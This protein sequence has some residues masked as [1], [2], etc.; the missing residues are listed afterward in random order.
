MLGPKPPGALPGEAPLGSLAEV[1]GAGVSL[2]ID[3]G[4]FPSLAS[5]GGAQPRAKS[6]FW[7]L[8]ACLVFLTGGCAETMMG[9]GVE[10]DVAQLRQ[11]V[12]A[13][14]L[15]VHRSRSNTETL[16]SQLDRRSREQHAESQKQLAALSSR[17]EALGN[18]LASLS[19]RVEDISQRVE[20]LNRQLKAASAPSAAG[21]P[22]P[23]TGAA[24]GSA[25]ASQPAQVYQAAYIDFSK[26][27]YP[28][29]IAG[30]REFLRKFPD[31]DLADNA[32]Y[33][34]GEAYFS[35]ARMY[36]TQGQ[37]DKATQELERAVQEFRKVIVNYPRGDK[38]PTALYKEA[39]VL[40]ELKQPSLARARLQYLLDHF[41]QSEEAPLAQERL[42]GLKDSG[43]R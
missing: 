43:A 22:R 36:A 40:L 30:F 2:K 17:T 39:L 16:L 4:G 29:A 15:S 13:L 7:L 1:G 11:D 28:L 26:G 8:F 38:A 23:S 31:S 21:A 35:L 42:A 34:I 19:A 18:E 12:D 5:P 3:L 27:N 25:A 14:T 32:Q 24:P 20:Q 6:G 10:R 9:A 41:P 37:P 33:W